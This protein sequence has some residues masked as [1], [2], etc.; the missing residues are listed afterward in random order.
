MSSEPLRIGVAGLGRIG[1]NFH[2]RRLADH[3]DFSLVAV[4]DTDPDRR[5]EANSTYGCTG[6]ESFDEMLD[7]AALD[8]VVVATPTHLHEAMTL[9]AF[10]HGLHVLLEKPMAMDYAEAERIVRAAE[11]AGRVLTVYQ[12]H[13]LNA[14]FQHLKALIES[15]RIGRLTRIQRGSFSYSRRN[16]WQSLLKFGGGMLSNYGAHFLDQV[17]QLIGYDIERVTCNLQLVA[18]LGDA[19]DVVDVTLR[20]TSGVVGNCLIS[21]ASVIKPYEFIAW[22]THGGIELAA[23]TFTVKSFDPTALP[24][25]EVDPSLGSADRKY[26]SDALDLREETIPVDPAFG[27]DVFANFAD[28]IRNGAPL[29]AP[30]RQTLQLMAVIEKCRTSAG[31]IRTVK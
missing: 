10:E 15:G 4:A 1:W 12:P 16:D 8:A 22:G 13:R 18:S 20:T 24:P 2:C 30:P 25:K 21:Q 23:N 7:N 28:A 11:D 31:D 6:H 26:P 3:P 19:D 9:N 17:M 5:A 27:I 14:Y 29:A